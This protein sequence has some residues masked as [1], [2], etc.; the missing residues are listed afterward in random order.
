[1]EAAVSRLPD[2]HGAPPPAAASAARVATGEIARGGIASEIARLVAL[3]AFPPAGS[4]VFLAV[5]GGA[6]SLALLVLAV[7][8][9]CRAVACH[10]DHGLRPG[11]AT[12]AEVVKA[13]ADR[14]GAG[15]TALRVTLE[16]GPNLEARARSARYAVLPAGVATGH[17]ADD[18]A[19][20][21]IL[22]LLRGAGPDGL[23]GM[24]R[25]PSH[26]ILGLRRSETR[27]LCDGLRLVPVED[28]SNADTSYLRNRVRHEV[29]PLLCQAAGRDLV[30]VLA[31]QA[32][33]FA[34]ESDF[35][36][37][38]ARRV[39]PRDARSLAG[40]PR[41]LARRA[42]RQWLRGVDE[43]GHPPDSATVERVLDVATL[44]SLACEVGGGRR[45]RRSAGRLRIEGTSGPTLRQK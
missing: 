40:A 28:P 5:S 23:A 42:V 29:L 7:A 13:A 36:E 10:V 3:C 39:D 27:S 22:N 6:D 18:Q 41:V 19:E 26:P 21:V 9:G 30:P 4:E 8:S 37:D 35:L 34:D 32:Q 45:V 25:G 1:M 16:P 11:S 14:F 43:E 2:G 33:H 17:T 20:T 15:Y 24:R 31:R 44:G 38:L 12:E